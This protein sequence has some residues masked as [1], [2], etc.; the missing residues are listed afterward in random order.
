[1]QSQGVEEDVLFQ[2]CVPCQVDGYTVRDQQCSL[3]PSVS[4]PWMEKFVGETHSSDREVLGWLEYV[5][6]SLMRPTRDEDQ[7]VA[8]AHHSPD[9]H[10][11]YTTLPKDVYIGNGC[12]VGKERHFLQQ[13][14][15]WRVAHAPLS[16]SSPMPRKQ[17]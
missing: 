13:C 11:S 9:L 8:S 7:S 5:L 12:Y 2:P 1:M 10:A 16:N 15:L 14:I 4:K 17:P 6:K 3:S